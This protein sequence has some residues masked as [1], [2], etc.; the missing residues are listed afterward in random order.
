MIKI[1]SALLTICCLF[2]ST[3]RANTNDA[4]IFKDTYKLQRHSEGGWFSEIYTAPFKNEGRAIAGSIYFLL[5]KDDVSHF[6]Q[7]DCDEI[8]YYHAGCGIKIFMLRD[9]KLDE[10]LLGIDAEK[11]QQPM[12]V[13]PARVIFAA[14]NLD[15]NSFTFVS[16]AT[17]PRFDYKYFRLV[18]RRELKKSYPD[19]PA[20]ILQMAYEKIPMP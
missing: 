14:E 2:M 5:D 4:E 19:L 3:A 8:W 16:C 11:N 10:I 17:T 15:K 20:Q 7:L 18:P 1:F 13:L 6:H 12:V 9:G